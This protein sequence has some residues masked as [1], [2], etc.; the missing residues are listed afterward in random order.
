VLYERNGRRLHDRV[1]ERL[2]Q[3]VHGWTD[4]QLD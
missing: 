2:L 1:I 4:R 3:E